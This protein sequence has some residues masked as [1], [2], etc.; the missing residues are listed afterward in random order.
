[1][2][3]RP[4]HLVERDLV[5]HKESDL[6]V[7]ILD[8]SFQELVLPDP[9]HDVLPKPFDLD[10]LL[11]VVIGIIQEMDKVLDCRH[12]DVFAHGELPV[13]FPLLF[14]AEDGLNLDNFLDLVAV[15]IDTG[16]VVAACDCSAKERL[17]VGGRLG[18]SVEMIQPGVVVTSHKDTSG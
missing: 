5:L 7:Q 15:V 2:P 12:R 17:E 4:I 18:I 14:G 8:M 3:S 9:M 10:L 11:I 16:F 6:D 13:L 1:L